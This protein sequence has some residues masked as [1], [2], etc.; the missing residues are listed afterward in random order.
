MKK[1]MACLLSLAM[2]PVIIPWQ[3][4]AEASTQ[5]FVEDFESYPVGV[6]AQDAGTYNYDPATSFTAGIGY[7]L[8]AGDKIE[9]AEENGNKYLKITR[10]STSTDF[11]RYTYFF[12]QIYESK[13]YTVSYDFMTE[14]HNQ[15]FRHF[16]SLWKKNANGTRGG[17]IKQITSFEDDIYYDTNTPKNPFYHILDTSKYTGSAYATIAQTVDF[18]DL[19]NS[20]YKTTLPDGT[21]T[22]KSVGSSTAPQGTGFFGLI[23]DI[24]INSTASYNG[25][26]AHTSPS[27][28]RIDNI[29]VESLSQELTATNVANGG[30]IEEHTPFTM[31]FSET[32]AAADVTLERNG[33]AMASADY[34]VSVSGQAVSVVPTAGWI[35]GS[36][37]TV[38][39]GRVAA[40]SSGL[41]PYHGTFTLTGS[42]YLFIE[43][44]ESYEVGTIVEAASD[45]NS[46]TT[47]GNINYQLKA[48]DKLAIVE[49]NG[50]KYL[51]I[52]RASESSNDSHIKYYFPATYSN[53]KYAISY[54]FKPDV[55][56]RYFARLGSLIKSPSGVSQ[57][58]ISY[59][60][61]VYVNNGTN[62]SY[63]VQGLVDS[64]AYTG[65]ATVTQVVDLATDTNNYAFTAEY[66]KTDGTAF[67]KTIERTIPQSGITGL[68]WSIDKHST[69][70]YNGP[71]S[72]DASV[73]RIDNIKVK[74]I[75][76]K[77]V[78]ASV[79]DGA[80]SVSANSAVTLTF[81]EPVAS[82]DGITVTQN[83]TALVKDTDYTL[84]VS[85]KT[86]TITPITSFRQGAELVISGTVTGTNTDIGYTGRMLTYY[87][88]GDFI[89]SNVK[90]SGNTITANL[91]NS[92]AQNKALVAIGTQLDG[93][94]NISFFNYVPI[95]VGSGATES[96]AIEFTSS[97]PTYELYIWDDFVNINPLTDKR[98]LSGS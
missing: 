62:A 46:A 85:D 4:K 18:T 41:D 64:T 29:R 83:G 1:L 19:S 84:S 42:S 81:A 90:I 2:L 56:N 37:Y 68:I 6:I 79:A 59:S 36:E 77:Y 93:S 39:V 72:G 16:G 92:T 80:T 47:V 31:T 20:K 13:K 95:T 91:L 52:T 86:V 32:V 57:T 53:K 94:G 22:E 98:T 40:T 25:G 44:F 7:K 49:E 3:E 23:W 15:Y 89:L 96:I 8:K 27:V 58:I 55:H 14:E 51:Q 87:T 17:V 74:A 60:K 70:T 45:Q 11:S 66:Q 10:G 43:D 97:A 33:M 78:S 38:N 5:V 73:Y 88:A 30:E 34:T 21:V 63:Y 9:I 35:E 24:Q 28:Y 48:G 67:T 75:P 61:N 50:N 71:D 26:A 65:Y 69:S 54:N 82:A 12:P 76:Q